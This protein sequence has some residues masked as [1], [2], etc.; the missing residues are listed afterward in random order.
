MPRSAPPAPP[1]P[2]TGPVPTP[3]HGPNEPHEIWLVDGFNV[4]HSGLLGGRDRANWWT[5]PRRRELLAR[6]DRFDGLAGGRAQLW[7]VFDGDRDPDPQPADAAG[8]D[9][10]SDAAGGAPTGTRTAAPA[11][12]RRVFAPS[13]DAWL[14]DRVRRAEQP[15]RHT[16]VTADR[17]VAGRVRARGA[18][19]VSPRA[20]LARC[21]A[22]DD[23]DAAG[24]AD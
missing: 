20:F 12:V 17:Q 16:V 7:V 13:A 11:A 8:D 5:E 6:A 15:E 23:A 9:P 24:G 19:V 1:A 3:P 14:V 21:P 10:P 4:L 22:D 18:R 2:P